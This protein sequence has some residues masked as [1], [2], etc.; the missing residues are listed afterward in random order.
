MVRRSSWTLPTK[1]QIL[2]LAHF[3]AIFRIFR[4]YALSGKCHSQ[5]QRG[6]NGDFKNLLISRVLSPSEV[7]IEVGYVYMCS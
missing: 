7:L 4:R 3:P 6:A 1:I 2:V 5:R